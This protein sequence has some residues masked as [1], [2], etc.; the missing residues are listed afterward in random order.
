M[1]MIDTSLLEI[2]DLVDRANTGG[3]LSKPRNECETV[4]KVI[5]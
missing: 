2:R 1:N 3:K 4:W 5:R